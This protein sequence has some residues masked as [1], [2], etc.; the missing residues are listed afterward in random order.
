MKKIKFISVAVSFSALVLVSS[1]G[2]GTTGS[3][4]GT[5]TSTESQALSGLSTLTQSSDLASLIGNVI[6]SITNQNASIVGTWVYTGPAVEFESSNFLA[7]AGGAIAGQTVANKIQPYFEKLGIK[8]GAMTMTFKSDNTCTYTSS[9]K[10]YSGKYVYDSS[11]NTLQISG[12]TTGISFPSCNV[13]VGTSS[14][15][16]TF[17]TSALLNAVQTVGSKSNNSTLSTVSTLANQFSGMQTG[18][19]FTKQQ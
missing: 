5:T 13:S 3:M 15:N 7:Q 11:A 9:G 17:K 14:L 12:I 2:L 10:T 8:A 6:G 4:N 1:C 18:F 19:Q 16:I